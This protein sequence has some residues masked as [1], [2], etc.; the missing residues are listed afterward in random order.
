MID[1]FVYLCLTFLLFATTYLLIGVL[2]LREQL[3]EVKK[4][5]RKKNKRN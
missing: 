5:C 3:K 2:D 4:L 1:T